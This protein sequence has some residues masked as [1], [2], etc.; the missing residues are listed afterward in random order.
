MIASIYARIVVVFCCLVALATSASADCAW[1]LWRDTKGGGSPE[2][3]VAPVSAWETRQQC[4]QALGRE[5]ENAKRIF[6]DS[7]VTVDMLSGSPRVWVS[8]SGTTSLSMRYQCLPDTVEPRG[9]K[10][11]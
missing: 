1:V 3:D 6:K 11:K 2:P 9:P 7:E 5:I 10:G 8:S 4:Q